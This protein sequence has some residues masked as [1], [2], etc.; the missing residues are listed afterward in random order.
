MHAYNPSNGEAETGES[1]GLAG[2][3]KPQTPDSGRDAASKGKVTVF[4]LHGSEGKGVC[5]LA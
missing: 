5:C 3:A 1:L 4:W 2:L